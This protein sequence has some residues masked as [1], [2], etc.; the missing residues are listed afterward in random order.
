MKHKPLEM[1]LNPEEV[2]KEYSGQT[3]SWGRG[4]REEVRQGMNEVKYVV[5][6]L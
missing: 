3:T 2:M 1:R 4:I 5:E 6:D